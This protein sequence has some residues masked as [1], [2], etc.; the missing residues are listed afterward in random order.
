MFS[1][2]TPWKPCAWYRRASSAA[3]STMASTLSRA[4][5]VPGSAPTWTT[6]MSARGTEKRRPTT[7]A[8]SMP[9]L[10]RGAGRSGEAP[11]S[12]LA[13]LGGF[14]F[15]VARRRAGD[16]RA[17]QTL[18]G[19]GHLGH[20]G[21]EGGGVGLGGRVRARDLAH[22]LQRGVAHLGFGHGRGEI[23]QGTDVSAHGAI[24]PDDSQLRFATDGARARAR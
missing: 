14:D 24:L 15:A 21:V 17:Q 1:M 6:P 13:R 2:A 20:G 5:G 22:E 19:C 9:D 11:A 8:R 4:L 10:R 16:Q 18:A 12:A 3:R 23:E 7:S